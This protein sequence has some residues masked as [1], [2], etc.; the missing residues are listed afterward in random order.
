MKGVGSGHFFITNTS[1]YFY[2]RKRKED[3]RETIPLDQVIQFV[4]ENSSLLVPN[5]IEVITNNQVCFLS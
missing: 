5:A 1:I 3:I 4:K 2:A